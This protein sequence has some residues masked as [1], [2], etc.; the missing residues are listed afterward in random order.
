MKRQNDTLSKRVTPPPQD[1]KFISRVLPGERACATNNAKKRY[2]RAAKSVSTTHVCNVLPSII[3]TDKYLKI[4][5][6]QQD[7]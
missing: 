5:D 4:I 2:I 7:G 6:T 1:I 3:F